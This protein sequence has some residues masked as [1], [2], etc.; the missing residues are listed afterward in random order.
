MREILMFVP[1]RL[2]F[3]RVRTPEGF[4]EGANAP[5][6]ADAMLA[7]VALSLHKSSERLWA[8]PKFGIYLAC[9]FNRFLLR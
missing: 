9:L 6:L 5:K 1:C 8:V 7:G 2:T 3:R 4:G